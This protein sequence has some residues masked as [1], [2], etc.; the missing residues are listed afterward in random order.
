M[1]VSLTL[2]HKFD[3]IQNPVWLHGSFDSGLFHHKKFLHSWL[4]DS[5]LLDS[6]LTVKF[7]TQKKSHK[8]GML[9]LGVGQYFKDIQLFPLNKPPTSTPEPCKLVPCLFVCLFCSSTFQ[10]KWLYEYPKSRGWTAPSP[11]S[12][13]KHG[14]QERPARLNAGV[15]ELF[16]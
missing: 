15:I 4:L 14:V 10:A 13:Q 5:W 11:I 3:C 8:K 2:N 9:E 16:G 7:L 1:Q 12:L 6:W